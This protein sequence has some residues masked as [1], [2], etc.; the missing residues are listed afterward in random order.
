MV[1][2]MFKVPEDLLGILPIP[3][4][5]MAA[6]ENYGI[7]TSR[8]TGE[9][10]ASE[11]PSHIKIVLEKCVNLRSTLHIP[12]L[13]DY[14]GDKSEHKGATLILLAPAFEPPV[15]ERNDYL[16]LPPTIQKELIFSKSL[17]WATWMLTSSYILIT[18]ASRQIPLLAS[19]GLYLV[20]PKY[21]TRVIL[22][23]SVYYG[24]DE[25]TVLTREYA[26]RYQPSAPC[27]RKTT[28][29]CRQKRI[30]YYL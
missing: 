18:K 16:Y 12:C 9:R 1:H 10:S 14:W 3:L 22:H 24:N 21:L 13:L 2:P 23:R 5:T 8:L 27:V 4:C 11:L 17:P 28:L 6:W 26:L 30:S 19:L 20:P 7:S 29:I 15:S 25:N